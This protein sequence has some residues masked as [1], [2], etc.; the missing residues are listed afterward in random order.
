MAHFLGFS[1]EQLLSESF[2]NFVH[3]EDRQATIAEEAKITQGSDTI[4]FENRYRCR[5]GSY[6]WL[7]WTA[8]LA[9]EEQLI[10]ASAK[11][12]TERKLAE[13]ES[14]Q[15]LWRWRLVSEI[16]LK[17][18][19]SLELTEILQVTVTEVQQILQADQALVFQLHPDGSGTVI[20]EAV[21]PGYPVVLEQNI[22][23]SCF[24]NGFA[25]QYSQ[26]RISAI[27]DIE[28]ANIQPC[29]VE[30]L[31]QLAV[32]ANLVVPIIQQS[33]LWGLL[34][35]HQCDRPR[36]WQT[37]EIDLLKQL[38][39]QISV[40]ISQAELLNSLEAKVAER[41]VELERANKQL[42]L[43]Q[44]SIDRSIE[45]VICINSNAEI[46]YLN[47]AACQVLGY[48][49]D[50]LM[51]L[52]ISEIVSAFSPAAWTEH[53][54]QLRSQGWLQLETSLRTKSG[55]TILIDAI[56]EHL[57][58]EGQEYS[59]IFGRNITERKQIE[60]ELQQSQ[61][62]YKTL[63]DNVPG[64][65]YRCLVDR[66]WTA[67]FIDN[68]IRAICGYPAADFLQ[69]RRT[70]AS[71]IYVE[72]RERVVREVRAA[73]AQKRAYTIEHRIV[74]SDGVVR[75][76]KSKGQGIFDRDGKLLWLDGIL[77]DINE[78]KWAETLRR[79]QNRVLNMLAKGETL[80]DVLTKLTEGI[81]QLSPGLN[82]IIM[83]MEDDDKHLR[84]FIGSQ[85]PQ[86]YIDAIDNLP[87]GEK[88]G[89]CGRTAYL[90]ERTIVDN[91]ATSPLWA[92]YKHLILPY[93]FRACWSEPIKSE[94]GRVLGTFGLYFTEPRSPSTK[95]LE[96][97]EA[98]ASLASVAI[99]RKQSEAAL[100]DSE[101][102][103]RLITDTLPVLVS[104]VDSQQRYQFVNK[105][106]EDWYRRPRTQ[107]IGNHIK[108]T[109][110]EVNYQKIQQHIESALR[111]N[112]LTFENEVILEDGQLRYF[113]AT[114]IPDLDRAGEVKGF[115]ALI[116][117]ISD[118]KATERMKNEFISVVSHE[119]RTP[120]TSIYGA[121]K[122]LATNPESELSDEDST[123]LDI[124]VSNTDRLIRLVN[125]ILDLERIESG[126][127]KILPQTCDAADLIHQAIE[128]MQPMANSQRVTLVTEPISIPLLADG[129]HIH[130]TLT[131]LLSNAIKFSDPDSSVWVTVENRERE[132]L[133]KVSDRGRG[134]PSD[135]LELIFERFQQVDASDS[136]DKGGT[137]LGLTICYKI[138]EEHGGRI[139]AESKLGEGSKFYFT[140]PK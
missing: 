39:N 23:D 41:T 129:D 72:D 89:S 119:L 96:I 139:W 86:T 36:H 54:Q 43:A 94:T 90:G 50:R 137:G 107:I 53:W 42:K 52:N 93:G 68:E 117:D 59:C 63:V 47:D 104:Y 20:E 80:Y 120:L 122:L 18:R 9:T 132:V 102:Q 28:Q 79:L 111:G 3:L 85:M 14:Q 60:Q 25:Q 55:G 29:Y 35:V 11:D 105:T 58:V 92:D 121:L 40:A 38:A 31:Q 48:T 69:N 7:L 1:T 106:Y 30:F 37:S 130:Q 100:H 13:T 64:A 33:G 49:R 124:A 10:Y 84:S 56:T 82:S 126:R 123:M 108:E 73:T 65:I 4:S 134:I 131:N 127:V 24:Q 44:F 6:K 114:Y 15:Q 12:I 21:V 135:K 8:T 103:L 67:L 16:T 78:R 113:N 128:V 136:R 138:V 71:I 87:I 115:T 19:Q 83:M 98:C 99:T 45:I 22:Y 62:Q 75:W 74:R 118:R 51:S 32:K 109:I 116:D 17:I 77:L 140:L 5:D 110:G 101:A 133:F 95:K 76:V 125:D 26:G 61:Q 34:I 46:I 97:I 91:I 112:T 57:E 27:A 81:N 66:H 70:L 2:I 88:V